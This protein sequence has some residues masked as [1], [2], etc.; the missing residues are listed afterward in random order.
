MRILPL[1]L[2][3]GLFVA[4][5]PAQKPSPAATKATTMNQGK[6]SFDVAMAPTDHAPATGI[7]SMSLDKSYHGDLEGKGKG[8][9]LS[10]GDPKLGNAGYVAIETIHGN[11]NGKTGGF[12]LMQYGL[13]TTGVEPKLIATIV[14]GSGTGELSGIYGSMTLTPLPGG[15]H[16]FTID[17][18]FAPK[19]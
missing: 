9:M 17:Y 11:L 12:A 14:P 18:A 15:K 16:N 7:S 4:P 19:K 3:L 2:A 5:S 10:A 6:G 8:E 1:T 13:M